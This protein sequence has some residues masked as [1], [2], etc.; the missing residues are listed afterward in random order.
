M[1]KQVKSMRRPFPS[2]GYFP[3]VLH[4]ELGTDKKL[5]A[6]A[7]KHR[8]VIPVRKVLR[9]I[10]AN[11][12]SGGK[13]PLSADDVK[14]VFLVPIRIPWNLKG[15]HSASARRSALIWGRSD[16]AYT[17]KRALV[18]KGFGN[19]SR[20]LPRTE[21]LP[22]DAF[23]PPLEQDETVAVPIHSAYYDRLRG[24]LRLSTIDFVR[25]KTDALRAEYAKAIKEGDP[26]ALYAFRSGITDLPIP[27]HIA[28]FQPLEIPVS[29]FEGK[30]RLRAKP[31][32]LPKDERQN[33][34]IWLY[35]APHPHRLREYR[36][37]RSEPNPDYRAILR[38]NGIKVKG[39]KLF[40]A[41]KPVTS[42]NAFRHVATR[43]AVLCALMVH[44]LNHRLNLSANSLGS[45][46]F[47][48]FT[49]HNTG[50]GAFFDFENVSPGSLV[51]YGRDLVHAKET[52][53]AVEKALIE[54]VSLGRKMQLGESIKYSLSSGERITYAQLFDKLILEGKQYADS[55]KR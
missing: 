48:V 3:A 12:I 40:L 6:E 16:Y 21:R 2:A 42:E 26:V 18:L 45:E 39:T 35:A 37:T 10:N 15:E 28:A 41:G 5:L 4:S 8:L 31:A 36:K 14:N 46:R 29:T 33:W 43:H 44:L 7:V 11:R 32:H 17:P 27:R 20:V 49:D 1:A 25:R 19:T 54:T 52:I 24:G 9:Q 13:K 30:R 38:A 55:L 50:P 47:T 23:V 51:S 53:A 22:R 34:R